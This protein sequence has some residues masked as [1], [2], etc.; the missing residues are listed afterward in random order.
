MKINNIPDWAKSTPYDR[1]FDFIAPGADRYKILL[2]HI[3][4]LKLNPVVISVDGNR[5]I[6]IFPPRQKSLRKVNIFPFKGTKPYLFSAH[7]DRVPDSPGAND[8]SIAVF[9]L[10]NA[11]VCLGQSNIDNWMIVFTDKE[12][13]S[14]GESFENQGSFTLAKK[15]K[16]WGLVNV[17]I[18]NFDVCGAGNAFLISTTTDHILKNSDSVNICKVRKDVLDLRDHALVTAD[19]MRLEKVL[20]APTPFS[21]DAGFLCAGLA[22]QTITILPC[23]EAEQYE[24]LLRSQKDFADL[25]ISGRIKAPREYRLLPETWRNLNNANDTPS[26]LTPQYFEQT[27]KYIVALA[28][29]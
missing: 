17:R 29:T 26:R 27:V 20:L 12:E 16:S 13:I 2:E 9:H 22:A 5:H 6:F 14:L 4:S 19:N 3:E 18:Y 25:I 21:D 1:Y 15:L 24:A 11:A 7:Y 28:K 23:K 10:L 8:N